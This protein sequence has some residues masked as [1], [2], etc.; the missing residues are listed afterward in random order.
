LQWLARIPLAADLTVRGRVDEAL[1]QWELLIDPTQCALPDELDQAIRAVLAERTTG[2]PP[3]HASVARL[4]E[5]AQELR[6]S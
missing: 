5:L 2:A 1:A 4:A 6:F 3:D